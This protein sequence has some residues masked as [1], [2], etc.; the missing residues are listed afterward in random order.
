MNH[1][2]PLIVSS[3]GMTPVDLAELVAYIKKR[4]V[5]EREE[6]GWTE[7]TGRMYK[8]GSMFAKWKM[9]EAQAEQDFKDRVTPGGLYEDSNLSQNLPFTIASQHHDRITRDL[10]DSPKFFDL[11]PE[12]DEDAKMQAMIMTS[13]PPDM[14][15]GMIVPQQPVKPTETLMRV[16]HRESRSRDMHSTLAKGIKSALMRG[17]EILRPSYERREVPRRVKVPAWTVNG[18]NIRD[19]KN[20]V[21]MA[22]REWALDPSKPKEQAD[23]VLKDDPMIRL[24]AGTVIAPSQEFYP[25]TRMKVVAN[26]CDMSTIYWADFVMPLVSEWN[27]CGF[28]GHFYRGTVDGIMSRFKKDDWTKEGY[29]YFSRHKKGELSRNNQTPMVAATEAVLER[30]ETDTNA[31]NTPSFLSNKAP[32]MRTFFEWWGDYDI[33]GSGHAEPIHVQLDW[34]DETVVQLEAAN[35]V[36]PWMDVPS[37][38]PYLNLRVFPVDKRWFGQSY[39]DIYGPWHDFGDLCWNRANLDIEQSGNMFFRQSGAYVNPNDSDEIGFR[40]GIIYDI[41]SGTTGSQAFQ[42]VNVQSSAEPLLMAMDRT[43]QRIQSHGGTMGAAD[44]ATSALPG[45]DTLGGLNKILEQGDVFVSARE[46]ELI[47][48]L[49]E[50]VRQIADIKI[51]A[52]KLDPSQTIA[53]VGQEAGMALMQFLEAMPGHIREYLEVNLSKAFGSG[54]MQLVSAMI[55]ITNQWMAVPSLYKAQFRPIYERAFRGLGVNDPKSYLDDP[56]AAIAMQQQ[57]MAEQQGGQP[58]MQGAPVNQ[59]PQEQAA[60]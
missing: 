4:A 36:L 26:G 7:G 56:E 25:V 41:L 32:H 40:S 38:N 11:N 43:M 22:D 50:A 51:H 21:I 58:P 24:P 2:A 23:L 20:Q 47:P 55:Q 10:L 46:R 8:G 37:P 60:A 5:Y 16:L 44:P 48:V 34:E 35:I 14:Q 30:G 3:I 28:R 33:S 15:P 13:Q 54:Q 1:P 59:Q 53:Q 49:N 12:G 31:Q 18:Q 39:Y 42:A 17:H 19:S 6:L 45:A 9:Y 57:M 52:I 27:D 29:K